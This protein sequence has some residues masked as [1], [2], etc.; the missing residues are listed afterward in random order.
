MNSNIQ[1]ESLRTEP[2]FQ[3]CVYTSQRQLRQ[4]HGNDSSAAL[5]P[6]VRP[7]RVTYGCYRN[8]TESLWSCLSGANVNMQRA[9]AAPPQK[10]VPGI[11]GGPA[12]SITRAAPSLGL[13]SDVT[14]PTCVSCA[15][16]RGDIKGTENDWLYAYISNKITSLF[17]FS[18]P[19]STQKAI[20]SPFNI[21]ISDLKSETRRMQGAS[22][23]AYV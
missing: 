6:C 5:I 12:S 22:L 9:N 10:M 7:W 20:I 2:V 3:G 16:I 8:K 15:G 4:T 11:W 19:T 13:S 21:F 1:V 17:P 18:N 23:W 14:G